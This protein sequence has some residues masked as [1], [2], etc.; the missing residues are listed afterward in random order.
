MPLARQPLG[1]VSAFDVCHV[2]VVLRAL[3][4]VHAVVAI[5]VSFAAPTLAAWV[6][7]LAQGA[8]IALPAVLLWLV[9][10]CLLKRWL[11]RLPA[12]GQWAAAAALGG[13]S[14]GF[15][16]GLLVAVDIRLQETM[17]PVAPVLAGAAL[18]AALFY[19]LTLRA[20]ARLP[21][22]TAA[23]LAE[24]QSRIRPHF[25]FNTLNTAIALARLDP[26][27]T[28]HLLEDLAELFRVALSASDE[29]VSLAEEVALAQRYLAIEQIRF[30]DR[31]QLS[32]DLDEDAGAARVPPLLLQPLV[33]N[34]VRHGV[35]PSPDGG[36][37]R[38]RTRVKRAHAV[39]SIANT[40][41]RS[42]SR[43][44]NGMALRNVRERLKL[45]HDVAA[46]FETQLERDVF[47]VQIV[48][49]L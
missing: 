30:G 5:G 6:N 28:E 17:H 12:A 37:I 39:V 21:A 48:V 8:G 49:P 24:L 22:D 25:L 36:V 35:E 14:G 20:R 32:W 11:A 44:G 13:L 31:L 42:G 19:W 4:F 29:S 10:A 7:L 40:V 18:A 2:G 23:R 38:I 47:R 3:F 16:W 46:Q 41:P 34:A 26:A 27:R 9:S 45:M 1:P 33:E 43:P 15:G